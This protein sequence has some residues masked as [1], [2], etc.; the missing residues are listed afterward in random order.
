PGD[1][2]PTIAARRA[3]HGL[4]NTSSAGRQLHRRGPLGAQPAF[5]DGAVGIALDLHDLRHAVGAGLRE[6]DERAAHCA[7]RTHRMRLLRAVYAVLASGHGGLPEIEAEGTD[8][9]RAW[10][11]DTQL[12]EVT[13]IHGMHVV[14]RSWLRLQM[15]C[16]SRDAL[17]RS[18]RST[19][20]PGPN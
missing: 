11:H 8:R 7:V 14:S 3:A 17:S 1:L 12:H 9:Q 10:A 5:I 20:N 15:P 6:G 4:L 16:R 2:L 19:Q 13:P 18:P